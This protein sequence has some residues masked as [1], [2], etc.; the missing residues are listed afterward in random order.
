MRE[1]FLLNTIMHRDTHA[2]FPGK[3]LCPALHYIKIYAQHI[4]FDNVFEMLPNADDASKVH[5]ASGIIQHF[6]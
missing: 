3:K 2:M 5:L 4:Y 6:V 1:G